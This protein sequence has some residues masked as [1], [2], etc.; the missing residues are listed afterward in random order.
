MSLHRQ[1]SNP[2]MERTA[3]RSED[4]LFVI[5]LSVIRKTARLRPP[6]LILFSLDGERVSVSIGWLEYVWTG[7]DLNY[8]WT[9][10]RGLDLGRSRRAN[11]APTTMADAADWPEKYRR[12]A[13]WNR[14]ASPACDANH[15]TGR[16]SEPRASLRPTLRGRAIHAL[17]ARDVAAGSR[18]LILCLVRWQA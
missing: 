1:P 10:A 6:S 14:I 4:R 16:C 5:E 18:S 7:V 17:A 2:A 12:C 3:D 8:D 15:L 9:A 13:L 11:A